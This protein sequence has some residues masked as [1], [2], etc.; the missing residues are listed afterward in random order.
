METKARLSKEAWGRSMD[1]SDLAP[2]EET[3][4]DYRDA[5]GRS[6]VAKAAHRGT[7]ADKDTLDSD[8]RVREIAWTRQRSCTAR[9]T[10]GG[11]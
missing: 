7:E 8:G 1:A 11:W 6:Q 2:I 3:D 10:G 5:G 4:G 9:A